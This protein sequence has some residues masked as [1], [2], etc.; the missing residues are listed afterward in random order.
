[1][2]LSYR[3]KIFS[4]YKW[5]KKDMF[6]IHLTVNNNNNFHNILNILTNFTNCKCLCLLISFYI[7]LFVSFVLPGKLYVTLHVS[8]IYK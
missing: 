5:I 3:Q 8:F 7:S 4:S 2:I 6:I 1:M